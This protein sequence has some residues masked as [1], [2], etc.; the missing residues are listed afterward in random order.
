M[1]NH[2]IKGH[3]VSYRRARECD[4]F[5]PAEQGRIRVSVDWETGKVLPAGIVKKER[6]GDLNIHLPGC[7]FDFR[8][9]VNVETPGK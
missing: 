3:R 8:I 7:P 1:S 4:R 5:Y 6:L 9:S 2:W